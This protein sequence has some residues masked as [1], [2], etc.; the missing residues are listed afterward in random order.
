[1]CVCVC[2]INER[3]RGGR[4]EEYAKCVVLFQ[5]WEGR[6]VTEEDKRGRRSHDLVCQ[7]WFSFIG[8]EGPRACSATTQERGKEGDGVGCSCDHGSQVWR[9][10]KGSKRGRGGS[11]GRCRRRQEGER[12]G[13]SLTGRLLQNKARG[14][15]EGAATLFLRQRRGAGAL[16]PC[17]EE[18]GG[19]LSGRVAGWAPC[20]TYLF[21]LKKN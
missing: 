15:K 13:G 6:A 2:K 7:V 12:E 11:L 8:E 4:V 3:E 17:V 21:F 9:C 14:R 5:R 16:A 10:F 1:M 19:G 18:G 20:L